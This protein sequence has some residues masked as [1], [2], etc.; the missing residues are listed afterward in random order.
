MNR[1]ERVRHYAYDYFEIYKERGYP[2]NPL[3]DW[4]RAEHIVDAE[5]E[6]R[7]RDDMMNSRSRCLT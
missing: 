2:P 6:A 4:L 7:I 5:D 1:E 3:R